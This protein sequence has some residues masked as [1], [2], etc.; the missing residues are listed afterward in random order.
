M[1]V[2]QPRK[3][4]FSGDF[5]NARTGGPIGG[6]GREDFQDF[7]A[8]NDQGALMGGRARTVENAAA[9]QNQGAL[10]TAGTRRNGDAA[11]IVGRRRI[12]AEVLSAVLKLLLSGKGGRNQ[13]ENYT[14]GRESLP[15][16][17]DCEL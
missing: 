3:N 7:V 10:W 5:E 15:E 12:H 16:F 11:R 13:K 6:I 1:E 2:N 17:S 4:G 9:A 8:L 14:C